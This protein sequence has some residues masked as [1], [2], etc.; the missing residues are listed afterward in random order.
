MIKF[1]NM[2]YKLFF[3]FL[4]TSF[5]ANAQLTESF[6]GN[7]TALPAGW[8]NEY[9][10]G[11][12]NWKIVTT[13]QNNTVTPLSPTYMA[14]FRVTDWTSKTKFV[15][16]V[17][18]LSSATTPTLKFSFANR[19][20]SGDVEELRIFYKTSASGAWTAVGS[21]YTTE[22]SS[23]TEV[24]LPLP[25]KSATYY[26]AFE[27]KSNY[28]RGLNLDN[29]SV[30]DANNL[31]TKEAAKAEVKIYPNPVKD[32]LNIQTSEKIN[33]I[34]VYS[35]TG[36]LLKTFNNNDRQFNLSDLTKGV[37]LLRVKYTGYDQSYKI[38]KE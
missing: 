15:T 33:S 11:T 34:Q 31:S 36:K 20:W 18:D 27:G 21:E 16:P 8:T 38:I 13:N 17:M 32:I 7:G 1:Y 35:L 10:D 14:E 2:K 4:M 5:I 3:A 25:N 28:A 29:I 24:T 23:W 22:H 30:Y 12:T 37:Y 9:V 19:S 26:V 6:D